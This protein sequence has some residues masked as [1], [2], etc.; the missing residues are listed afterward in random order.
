MSSSPLAHSLSR[1]HLAELDHPAP[2]AASKL[3]DQAS[4]SWPRRLSIDSLFAGVFVLIG[5]RISGVHSIGYL[6]HR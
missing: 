6:S 5:G 4:A 3:E 2:R 1:K